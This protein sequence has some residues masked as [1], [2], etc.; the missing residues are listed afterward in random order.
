MGATS[1]LKVGAGLSDFAGAAPARMTM[2]IGATFISEPRGRGS[3]FF[4]FGE[5]T[6]KGFRPVRSDALAVH[7]VVQGVAQVMLRRLAATLAVIDV[8]VIDPAAIEKLA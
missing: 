5:R 4:G 6:A 7:D 3:L 2:T 1:L 8:P